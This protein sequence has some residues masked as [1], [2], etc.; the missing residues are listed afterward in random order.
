[1]SREA[2]SD[3]QGWSGYSPARMDSQTRI[4]VRSAR[5]I[6]LSALDVPAAER[7]AFVERMC[8][9]DAKLCKEVEELLREQEQLGSFMEAPAFHDMGSSLGIGMLKGAGETPSGGATIEKPGDRIDRYKLLQ[10]VGE[11]GC[12]IVY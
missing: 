2:L 9:G 8:H 7:S 5:N 4:V 3:S 6:F 12:G 11:G 10:K 1:M